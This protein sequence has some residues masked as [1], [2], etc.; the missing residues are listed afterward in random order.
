MARLRRTIAKQP[1]RRSFLAESG[2]L[3]SFFDARL[4][5]LRTARA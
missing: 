5:I 3:R 1:L 4:Y 2:T